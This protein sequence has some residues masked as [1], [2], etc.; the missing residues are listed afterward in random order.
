MPLTADDQSQER[1]KYAQWIFERNLHWIAAAEV[2]V[3]VIVA[4]DT[5]MLGALAAILKDSDPVLRTNAALTAT[6]LAACFLGI[7]LFCAAFAVLPRISGPSSSYIFFGK[8]AG[9]QK[10]KDFERSFKV[11]SSPDLLADCLA[12]IH[13]NAEIAC[14]KFGSGFGLFA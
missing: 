12:Q 3:G 2:K 5:G 1:L 8:I 6:F 14:A 9:D 11:A 10:F 4:I 13:R 7:A